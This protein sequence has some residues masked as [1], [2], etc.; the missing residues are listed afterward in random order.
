[1]DTR[2]LFQLTADMAAIEDAL[3]ETGG[4]LTEELD[5][6]LTETSESLTRKV[7]SYNGLIR[8]FSYAED[9][10]DAEIAR[11]TQRK[12]AAQRAQENLKERVLRSMMENGIDKL[13]GTYC[14]MIKRKSTKVETADEY[15]VAPYL[16]ELEELRGRLPSHITLPD[17]KVNKTAIKAMYKE[18]GILVAG[19]EIVD[20]YTLTIR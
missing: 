13:E 1:M 12:K 17:L 20:N 8:S 18:T 16:A 10:I 9:M 19:A 7:D 11:L 5:L 15:I 2:T 3:W 14:K 4:E 6:A